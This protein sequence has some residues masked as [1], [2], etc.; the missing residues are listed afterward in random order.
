MLRPD[1]RFYRAV[2]PDRNNY[3]PEE[4][5]PRTFRLR[6]QDEGQLSLYDSSKITAREC[7]ELYNRN[8]EAPQAR[9]VAVITMSEL[10]RLQLSPTPDPA[11]HP[12]HVLVSM[13]HLDT[14]RQTLYANELLRM[15]QARGPIIDPKD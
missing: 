8:P 10:A 6:E 9:A 1:A 14:E 7:L 12:A 3:D 11:G 5:P 2:P 4:L 15:A 13:T